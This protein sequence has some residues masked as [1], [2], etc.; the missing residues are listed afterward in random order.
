MK[1]AQE[2]NGVLVNTLDDLIDAL[3]KG[4]PNE[5]AQMYSQKILQ[6]AYNIATSEKEEYSIAYSS[7]TLE[8][9]AS[10]KSDTDA[11]SMA[12][13]YSQDVLQNAYNFTTSEIEQYFKYVEYDLGNGK[14][15]GWVLKTGQEVNGVLV[16]TL[17]DLIN[18]LTKRKPNE[19]AQ[20]YSQEVLRNAYNFTTSEIEQYFKYVEY[21][22]GNG[23]Q[24]GWV[25]KTAQEVNGLVIENLDD[26][27]K[28]IDK[29]D[30]AKLIGNNGVISSGAQ[31]NP[32][33][34]EIPIILEEEENAEFTFDYTSV[35]SETL[36]EDMCNEN[37][38]SNI[39]KLMSEKGLYNVDSGAWNDVFR[40]LEK[41]KPQ[42]MN[43]IKAQMENNGL[44]Y[45]AE[46]AEKY[47][48]IYMTEAVQCSIS[49]TRI[50]FWD[51]DL[52]FPENPTIEDL[53]N[54][55]R[56]RIDSE[57]EKYTVRSSENSYF[58]KAPIKFKGST[59]ND[60][61]YMQDYYLMD[62]ADYFLT[63]EEKEMKF[64]MEVTQDNSSTH[65]TKDKD[66]L[67]GYVD[68]YAKH[69]EKVLKSEYSDFTD[70]QVDSIINAAK[71][72]SLYM[73]PPEPNKEGLYM[74]DVLLKAFEEKCLE[75][76]EK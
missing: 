36:V 42:L 69:M 9:T 26:L 6:N 53:V 61:K 10:K 37:E 49:D 40:E 30:P 18:A 59:F 70:R 4:K 48:E 21:D 44:E 17:D 56:D 7:P 3:T 16:N 5:L 29:P 27:L 1:T 58:D 32:T 11:G 72:Y 24:S 38:I 35:N 67:I 64:V 76:A 28:A 74:I 68:T 52:E 54:Y 45:N 55:I 63:E 22:L 75:Y 25:L 62:I 73:D 57:I 15:S 65:C 20:M 39:E 34:P 8:E 19:L 43:Y 50:N 66:L 51:E 47:I 46:N 31:T 41:M 60:V 14:Q 71:T 13:V 12:N 2:V 23:K 33:T